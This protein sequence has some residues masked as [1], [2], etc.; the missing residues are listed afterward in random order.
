MHG[1]D[2]TAVAACGVGTCQCLHS[3]PRVASR[4]ILTSVH[5]HIPSTN[6]GQGGVHSGSSPSPSRWLQVP[7]SW[8]GRGGP[9]CPGGTWIHAGPRVPSHLMALE[10]GA[11]AALEQPEKPRLAPPGP[12]P[13]PLAPTRTL[14]LPVAHCEPDQAEPNLPVASNVACTPVIRIHSLTFNHWQCHD[15]SWKEQLECATPMCLGSVLE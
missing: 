1:R 8:Q 10:I 9:Q 3:G 2:A 5:L 12:G 11:S 7:V 14:R 4:S 13:G 15:A 6:T